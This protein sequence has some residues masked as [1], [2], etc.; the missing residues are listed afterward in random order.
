[1]DRRCARES[2]RSG[3]DSRRE[4]AS[5]R[6]RVRLL[7]H[8]L[9]R[10]LAS[11]WP[12]EV[13][14]CGVARARMLLTDCLGPLYSDLSGPSIGEAVWWIADGLSLCP[15]HHWGCPVIMKLDPAHVAWTCGRCGRI[16][17][18]DDPAVSPA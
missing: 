5:A 2:R 14:P 13:N 8:R 17:T 11:R 16:A 18:S 6:I 1:M 15:P 4:P 7:R 9:D 3:S 12:A 10:E